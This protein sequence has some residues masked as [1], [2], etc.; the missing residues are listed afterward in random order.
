MGNGKDIKKRKPRDGRLDPKF[1]DET[2]NKYGMLTVIEYVP[3]YKT[4]GAHWRCRC[5]CGMETITY[6]AHLR[7]GR[8]V[9][10]GCIREFSD[11]ERMEMGLP[12]AKR[13]AVAECM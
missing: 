7:A 9:S 5:E 6:G 2:G 12:L 4:P 10:C 1:I 8:V 11:A 13:K 3:H